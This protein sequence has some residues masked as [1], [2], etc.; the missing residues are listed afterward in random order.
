[1]AYL[2][3][4]SFFISFN[5]IGASSLDCPELGKIIETLE[6]ETQRKKIS[7]C[8]KLTP[9]PTGDTNYFNEWRCRDLG[10]I[11][12]ELEKLKL[13]LMVS[14]GF[15][16]LKNEIQHS[17]EKVKAN[18]KAAARSFISNLDIAHSFEALI[19][20]SEK[21]NKSFIE[22]L[23]EKV[24]DTTNL[25]DLKKIIEE[26]CNTSSNE[27]ACNNQLVFNDDFLTELKVV[28]NSTTDFKKL[29]DEIS[30]KKKDGTPYSFED[31]KKALSDIKA[32][33]LTRA[34]LEKIKNI[35]E[36]V[37][38][39]QFDFV[40]ELSELKNNPNILFNQWSF[41][42]E[43]TVKRMEYEVSHKLSVSLLKYKDE[44]KLND[45]D[46]SPCLQGKS[47][48]VNAKKCY[49]ILKKESS[50]SDNEDLK[51]LLGSIEASI[52]YSDEVKK[53]KNDCATAFKKDPSNVE[54]FKI[55]YNIKENQDKIN[56]LNELKNKI[57]SEHSE[58][59][60]YRNFA[61][62]QWK[63]NNCGVDLSTVEGCEDSS[64]ISKEVFITSSNA[65]NITALFTSDP[66]ITEEAKKVCG[67]DQHKRTNFE[68]K[69]C[70]SLNKKN[71]VIVKNEGKDDLILPDVGLSPENSRF[72]YDPKKEARRVML[73][74]TL[75]FL[76]RGAIDYI[77]YRMTP[78]TPSPMN[79]MTYPTQ[80]GPVYNFSTYP[81]LQN[82]LNSPFL[83]YSPTPGL[84]PYRL[85][86]VGCSV[87]FGD[88]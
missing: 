10:T 29:K 35:D 83:L 43:D 70:S 33:K 77:N 64:K 85:N 1:M 31:M 27:K 58:S 72:S 42:M 12:I 88:C 60:T 74:H 20:S 49:E 68:E 63:E 87:Y 67:S 26:K 40:K 14:D 16:K 21:D 41:S 7:D 19:H 48:I 84:T 11:E 39:N 25:A 86:A 80:P 24:T 23:K 45:K 13:E 61:L 50:N 28:L 38:N 57:I 66:K 18:S 82:Y 47:S 79:Y 32:N 34:D 78:P 65:L 54:C 62:S 56:Q 53:A 75:N 8:S 5:L 55:P 52:K 81:M 3:F 15:E 22:G 6:N 71:P 37:S 30:I 59:L 2:F 73:N 44:L 46:I 17:Q 69:L 36:F 76:G 9:T 4:M 51:K